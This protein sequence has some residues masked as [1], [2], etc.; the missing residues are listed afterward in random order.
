MRSL[1]I[2][3]GLLLAGCAGLLPSGPSHERSQSAYVIPARIADAAALLDPSLALMSPLAPTATS[4]HLY[5]RTDGGA[6][7]VVQLQPLSDST[8][9]ARVEVLGE[10]RAPSLAATTP[11]ARDTD[12]TLTFLPGWGDCVDENMGL[13]PDAQPNLRGPEPGDV[14]PVLIGGLNGLAQ[15]VQYPSS[16]RRA[17]QH[18]T[19]YVSFVVEHDGSIGCASI[20]RGSWDALNTEAL[21]VVR[22]SRFI[23]GTTDGEPV[24]VRYTLPIRFSL[25]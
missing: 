17:G 14:E 10:T 6:R 22:D 4:E 13:P 16:A 7:T 15:R 24:K 25:R 3:S 1:L 19:V 23:P 12:A 20:F 2:Y 11:L 8:T 21:R 5:V 18:G 9:L